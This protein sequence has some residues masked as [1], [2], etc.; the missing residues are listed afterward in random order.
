MIDSFKSTNT[1]II[2]VIIPYNVG[3]V[4][5]PSTI[6]YTFYTVLHKQNKSLGAE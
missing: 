6:M 2:F 4:Q 3:N 5:V 1:I